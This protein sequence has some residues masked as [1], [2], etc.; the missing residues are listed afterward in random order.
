MIF[1]E[2]VDESKNKLLISLKNKQHKRRFNRI[3]FGD[4][5]LVQ[6]YHTF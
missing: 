2:K 6:K 3:I 4:Q 1:K 5:Q